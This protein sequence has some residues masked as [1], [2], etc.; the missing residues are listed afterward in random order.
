MPVRAPD[1][2]VAMFRDPDIAAQ[3]DEGCGAGHAGLISVPTLNIG[4]LSGGLKVNVLPSECRIE[5]DVRLPVGLWR[6]EMRALSPRS[7]R[8]SRRRPSRSCRRPDLP[9]LVRPRR[10][11]DAHH[12]GCGRRSRP[13]PPVPVITLGGTDTRL[14]RYPG[15]PAYVYGASPD[16]MAADDENVP[17]E[18]FLHILKTHVLAAL[19]YLQAP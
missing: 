15:V 4:R 3:V 19:R 9:E 1:N 18:D 13:P 5:A 14:W 12:P 8:A 11:D 7:L 10:R 2:L 6:E 17:I 16:T